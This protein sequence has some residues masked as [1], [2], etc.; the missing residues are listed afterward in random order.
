MKCCSLNLCP[1]NAS[2]FWNYGFF[3]F[4]L[5]FSFTWFIVSSGRI[6]HQS[7]SFG[8]FTL[9]IPVFVL[10]L[11]L[12]IPLLVDVTTSSRKLC[13][14]FFLFFSLLF[15]FSFTSFVDIAHWRMNSASTESWFSLDWIHF[16]LQWRQF[17]SNFL[18]SSYEKKGNTRNEWKTN[19]QN[20]QKT[21]NSNETNCKILVTIFKVVE[22][23]VFSILQFWFLFIRFVKGT[24]KSRGI[25][26]A[27]Y[28]AF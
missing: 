26:Y 1:C 22:M 23:K 16:Y 13:K 10:L 20:K 2:Q 24:R 12:R 18:H 9:K 21:K 17:P 3:S 27:K 4:C 5:D 19:E 8:V 25:Y 11:H 15:N 28:T 6:Y 14:H 7:T